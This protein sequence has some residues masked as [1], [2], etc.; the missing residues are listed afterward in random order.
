MKCHLFRHTYVIPLKQICLTNTDNEAT[1]ANGQTKGAR[2][3]R[4]TA[5][6]QRESTWSPQEQA[7]CCYHG[8]IGNYARE[9]FRRV[10]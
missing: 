8:L 4:G 10:H 5:Q 3:E 9:G 1:K 6:V 2:Y 7:Q